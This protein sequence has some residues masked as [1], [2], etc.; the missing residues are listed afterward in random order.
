MKAADACQIDLL[1]PHRGFEP[2]DCGAGQVRPVQVVT[3]T[4]GSRTTIEALDWPEPMDA[5]PDVIRA[6][7]FS[8]GSVEGFCFKI[9]RPDGWEFWGIRFKKKKKGWNMQTGTLLP[10][11]SLSAVS[12]GS[13]Y[14]G[15]AL[16]A[17][18]PRRIFN[19]FEYFD[20]S[21]VAKVAV[22]FINGASPPTLVGWVEIRRD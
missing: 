7:V 2:A 13:K 8:G 4:I 1:A 5:S 11:R 6:T 14:A 12:I 10:R 19:R 20:M 16:H 17:S 22:E 21:D 15:K 9:V 18:F 3:M